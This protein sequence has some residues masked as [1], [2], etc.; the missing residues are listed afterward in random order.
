[1]D[2]TIL[3]YALQVLAVLP[4]LIAAGRSVASIVQDANTALAAMQAENRDPTPAEWDA[5]N[6]QIA[7][8][9]S[10]LHRK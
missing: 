5:L 9:R 1:M 7:A 10:E 6:A 4:Q 3:A 8:L 2:T